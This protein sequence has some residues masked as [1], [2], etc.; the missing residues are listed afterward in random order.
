MQITERVAAGLKV[1]GVYLFVQGI[2]TS[3]NA[4]LML[5]S[6]ILEHSKYGS[7]WFL[8]STSFAHAILLLA[9]SFVCITRTAFIV[10]VC[11]C[12]ESPQGRDLA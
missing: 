11:G 9:G 8:P 10:R 6:A 1:L 12:A 7:T 2:A 4:I 3:L 5:V